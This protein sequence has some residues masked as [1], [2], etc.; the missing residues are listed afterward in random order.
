MILVINKGTD[1]VGNVG[2]IVNI[3]QL[4]PLIGTIFPTEAALKK[5]FYENGNK[6]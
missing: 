6:R 3:V 1:T 5:T 2:T 4:I